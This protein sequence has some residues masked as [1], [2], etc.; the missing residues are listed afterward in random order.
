MT[1]SLEQ[2]S[3]RVQLQHVR[4]EG[5]R[6]HTGRYEW[7]TCDHLDCREFREKLHMPRISR[8]PDDARRLVGKL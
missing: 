7:R 1:E 6:G 4:A 3:I 8:C 5:T 2:E